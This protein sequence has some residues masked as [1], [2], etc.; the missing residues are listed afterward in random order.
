MI[1]QDHISDNSQLYGY[2]DDV[3]ALILA[4][5]IAQAQLKL[6]MVM[7]RVNMGMRDHLQSLGINKINMY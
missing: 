4:R 7:R 1:S 5:I 3:A 6:N 2:A